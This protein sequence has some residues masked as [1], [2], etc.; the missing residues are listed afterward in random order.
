MPPPEPAQVQFHEPVEVTAEGVP[1]LHSPAVGALPNCWPF[2]EPHAPFVVESGAEQEAAQ[3]LASIV[4]VHV[5]IEPLR[6]T[7]VDPPVTP[8]TVPQRVLGDG[9]VEEATPLA[10]PQAGPIGP[11]PHIT[12]AEQEA[13]H[14][15]LP[16]Y[17]H[18][19]VQFGPFWVTAPDPPILHRLVVGAV[20][21][22]TPLAEPHAG[23][24]S[25]LNGLV[26]T[27]AAEHAL[28]VAQA[29]GVL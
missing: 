6:V 26:I 2:A 25:P 16:R 27:H 24:G 1:A 19:Q 21:E 20:P 14:C 23:G 13:A 3:V 12:G 9:A 28:T 8:P 7:P 11:P 5:H 22:A 17:V 18:V 15:T 29:L 4:H 10:E